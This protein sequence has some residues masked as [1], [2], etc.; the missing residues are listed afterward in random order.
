MD[1]LNGFAALH[2]IAPDFDP[3]T[4]KIRIELLLD[5]PTYDGLSMRR[6]GMRVEIPVSVPDPMQSLL[7][8]AA[9]VITRFEENQLVR[10]NGEQVRVIVL[11]SAP[12]TDDGRK[13]LRIIAPEIRPGD[14]FQLFPVQ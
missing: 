6:G 14:L 4:R 5:Q 13:W 7:I 8:P 3:L 10:Q 2:R 9:A 12:T 11:G 1:D